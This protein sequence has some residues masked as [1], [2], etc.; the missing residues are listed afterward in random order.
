MTRASPRP[1]AQSASLIDVTPLTAVPDS[2]RVTVP[3]VPEMTTGIFRLHL[4]KRHPRV[5]HEFITHHA[6]DHRHNPQ[7]DHIHEGE[8]KL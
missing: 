5:G 3:P 1:Y 6:E 7:L 8:P 4:R 2:E